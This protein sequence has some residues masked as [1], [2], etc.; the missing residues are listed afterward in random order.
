MLDAMQASSDCAPAFPALASTHT[1]M[2]GVTVAQLMKSLPCGVF[3]QA[4]GYIFFMA[5]SSVT[6]V[7]MTSDA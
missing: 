4:A 5:R 1:W 3:Q 7:M 6:T 2:S